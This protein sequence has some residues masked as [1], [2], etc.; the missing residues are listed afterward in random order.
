MN[1]YTS[2]YG[3][4]QYFNPDEFE[5][6]QIS[7]SIPKWWN[8]SIKPVTKFNLLVP[9]WNLVS[10]YK[11]GKVNETGY[12]N[13]YLKA[14]EGKS[15]TI[16]EYLDKI[17]EKAKDKN[18]V[19]LCYEKD[20]FCHRHLAAMFMKEKYGLKITEFGKEQIKENNIDASEHKE[21]YEQLSFFDR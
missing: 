11:A 18:I 17:I 2:Y 12:T 15:D 19:F 3:K 20:D 16:K 7:N 8:T 14:L 10:D 5:F 1:I 9:D 21:Q 6:V 4:A 13:V